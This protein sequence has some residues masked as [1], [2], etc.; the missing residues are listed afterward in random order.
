[1]ILSNFKQRILHRLQV[2]LKTVQHRIISKDHETP[3]SPPLFLPWLL[4]H[5][6]QTE[7]VYVFWQDAKLGNITKPIRRKVMRE[8]EDIQFVDCGPTIKEEIKEENV[9]FHDPLRL[10]GWEELRPSQPSSA[11]PLQYLCNPM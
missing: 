1:M 7:R 5:N 3:H 4:D 9:E 6:P 10:S 11:A 2:H 8:L